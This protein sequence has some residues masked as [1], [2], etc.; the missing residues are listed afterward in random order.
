MNLK[1]LSGNLFDDVRKI[2]EQAQAEVAVTVNKA[3]TVMYWEIGERI[4]LELLKGERAEYGKEI[5]SQLA[6]Q[7][8]N[9][10]GKRCFSLIKKSVKIGVLR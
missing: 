8:Q 1:N 4:N 5:V 2:I 6:S 3:L 9:Q 7:L 10:F